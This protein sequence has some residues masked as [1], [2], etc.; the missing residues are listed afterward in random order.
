MNDQIGHL[1]PVQ[2]QACLASPLPDRRAA[3]G[4]EEYAARLARARL[5]MH[6]AGVDALLVTAGMSLRYFVGPAIWLQPA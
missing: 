5:L 4:A 3:I 2:V 1:T 6:E